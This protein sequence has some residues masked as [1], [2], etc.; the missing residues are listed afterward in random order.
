MMP[1]ELSVSDSTIWSVTLEL[2]IKILEASF[3]L[4]FD[5]YSTDITCDNHHLT[6]DKFMEQ[7]TCDCLSIVTSYGMSRY[8]HKIALD[9]EFLVE[10]FCLFLSKKVN[11]LSIVK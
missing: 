11:T 9:C 6:I 3:S 10:F 1:L 2:P 8:M 5:V 4:Y 7:A